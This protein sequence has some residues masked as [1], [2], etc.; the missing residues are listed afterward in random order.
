[1]QA[2]SVFVVDSVTLSEFGDVIRVRSGC[3]VGYLNL[4]STGNIHPNFKQFFSDTT[5]YDCFGFAD[6]G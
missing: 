6:Q 5:N 1:M 4:S 2:L 3:V